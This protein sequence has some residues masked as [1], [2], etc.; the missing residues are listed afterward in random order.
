M[1]KFL[2]W[3]MLFV[4]FLLFGSSKS[5]A[6]SCSPDTKRVSV[7]QKV[8]QSL[9][10]AQFVFSGQVIDIE[11]NTG[12]TNKRYALKV[13]IKVDKFWKG[14]SPETFIVQTGAGGGDC[15]FPFELGESYLIYAYGSA[16]DDS[17]GTGICSRT[18]NIAQADE[19]LKILGKGKTP[20]KRIPLIKIRY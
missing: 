13:K 17:I 1:K 2:L 10:D 7:K 9:K 19:D 3:S 15:G 8:S 14:G 20:I 5:Y 12:L 4:V 6:C 18:K 16:K 11:S